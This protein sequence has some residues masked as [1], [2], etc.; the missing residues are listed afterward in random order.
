ME[1]GRLKIVACPET[2]PLLNELG[3]YHYDPS[4][5]VEEPVDE[6][7]HACDALR[8]LITGLDRGRVVKDRES[9]E[10]REVRTAATREQRRVAE[11]KANMKDWQVYDDDFPDDFLTSNWED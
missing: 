2:R 11:I 4:K 6:D 3:N 5:S 7:N 10:H 8:Y 9:D 1:S